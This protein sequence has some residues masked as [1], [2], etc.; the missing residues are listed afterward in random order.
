MKID[1]SLLSE[2]INAIPFLEKHLDKIRWYDLCTNIN[3]KPSKKPPNE[4]SYTAYI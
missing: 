3:A 4:V 1:W 2:N